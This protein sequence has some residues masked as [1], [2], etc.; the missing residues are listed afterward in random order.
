M[1]RKSNI[2]LMPE[3]FDRYINLIDDIEVSE[4]FKQ[5][6]ADLTALDLVRFSALG[7]NTHAPGKWTVRDIFQHLIDTERVL[8][9]RAVRFARKDSTPLPGFEENLFAAAARANRRSIEDIISELKVVRQSTWLMYQSFDEETMQHVGVNWNK[10]ISV[11]AM[12][13]TI[14]GHQEHHLRVVEKLYLP[15]MENNI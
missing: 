1:M 12:G 10:E 3:Y 13:F 11:L 15:L 4:A 8:S 14:V 7:D 5:S 2:R 9:Y 6:Y